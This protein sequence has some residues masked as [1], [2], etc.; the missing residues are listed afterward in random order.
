MTGF[1]G[2][3]HRSG[4]RCAIDPGPGQ[5]NPARSGAGGG[6]AEGKIKET[7]TPSRR[8]PGKPLSAHCFGRIVVAL[9]ATG[10]GATMRHNPL[11]AQE[12]PWPCGPKLGLPAA[13]LAEL[14]RDR[15]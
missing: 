14:T 6:E 7:G 10:Q 3:H 4:E 5:R 9:C 11:M 2:A 8:F 1:R 12:M 15:R 13:S